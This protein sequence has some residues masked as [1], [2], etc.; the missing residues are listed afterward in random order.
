MV[1]ISSF[2]LWVGRLSV[3]CDSTVCEMSWCYKK[4]C[5]FSC[6]S[7]VLKVSA[8]INQHYISHK[9][10]FTFQGHS[11]EDELA[12][13]LRKHVLR[14]SSVR[15]DFWSGWSDGGYWCW[16]FTLRWAK[17]NTQSIQEFGHC[18]VLVE[19]T[20]WG[21]GVTCSLPPMSAGHCCKATLCV[22]LTQQH[23]LAPAIWLRGQPGSPHCISHLRG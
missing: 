19:N 18:L 2:H 21:S 16:K 9:W 4:G 17:S 8:Q 15:Q 20:H 11:S 13:A 5:V 10:Q 12:T 1:L 7:A 22:S 3:T 14:S 23:H 6:S